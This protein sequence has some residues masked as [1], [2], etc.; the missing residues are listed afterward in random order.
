MTEILETIKPKSLHFIDKKN[1]TG[2][3]E[4]LPKIIGQ[5]R[6]HLDLG[7]QGSPNAQPS[8]SSPA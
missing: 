4:N 2:K 5:V 8:D 6:P 1:N 7:I 3:W